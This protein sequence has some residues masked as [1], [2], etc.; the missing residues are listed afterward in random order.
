MQNS[1]AA[2]LGFACL[3]RFKSLLGV[4]VIGSGSHRVYPARNH[5]KLRAKY[6]EL[7]SPL[8]T[9]GYNCVP[10]RLG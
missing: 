3:A 5:R 10:L 4:Q 7:Y 8:N 1:P 2:F 9:R 6:G